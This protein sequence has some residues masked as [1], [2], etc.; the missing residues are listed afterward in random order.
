MQNRFFSK[1]P[2]W[3][4]LIIILEI[5][6]GILLFLPEIVP[7]IWI[8]YGLGAIF[9]LYVPG[10]AIVRSLYAGKALD[11]FEQSALSIGLSLSLVPVIGFV[12]DL[13]PWRIGLATI[14]STLM[15]VTTGVSTLALYQ[16]RSKVSVSPSR[17]VVSVE[18]QEG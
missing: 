17:E 12:L 6:L 4:W 2:R 5:S 3:Y 13:T 11:N 15:L 9:I 7:V 1:I 18:N 14:V 16:E 10:Y 8:R